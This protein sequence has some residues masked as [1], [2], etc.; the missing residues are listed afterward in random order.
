MTTWCWSTFF[1]WQ[2]SEELRETSA[3]FETSKTIVANHPRLPLYQLLRLESLRSKYQK[4]FKMFRTHCSW[5][6]LAQCHNP[7]SPIPS[8]NSGARGLFSRC[9]YIGHSYS[10]IPPQIVLPA[11]KGCP[12]NVLCIQGS[13]RP[14][15]KYQT[16]SGGHRRLNRD[17]RQCHTPD[18]SFSKLKL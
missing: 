9:W 12:S 6:D 16:R 15:S 17:R 3:K 7:C 10:K 13:S 1:R 5:L 18:F 2:L 14:A 11:D 8:S 4:M